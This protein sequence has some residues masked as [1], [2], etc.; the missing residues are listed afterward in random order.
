MKTRKRVVLS[1]TAALGLG[2]KYFEIHTVYIIMHIQR[3][4]N[5]QYRATPL[6]LST[7]L[8]M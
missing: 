6:P 1:Y 8:C 4:E 5:L 3:A 2:M 7:A